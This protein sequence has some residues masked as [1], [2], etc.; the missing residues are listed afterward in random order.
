MP[1]Q[2]K[3]WR[4]EHG[5]SQRAAAERFGLTEAQW[6][7]WETGGSVP[8][9]ENLAMLAD[10]LGISLGDFYDPA[11]FA[12]DTDRVLEAI[13]RIEAKLDVLINAQGAAADVLLDRGRRS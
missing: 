6:V 5:C 13:A 3:Q 10:K 8:R 12:S 9:A 11:D 4:A 1:H 7:R 2:L